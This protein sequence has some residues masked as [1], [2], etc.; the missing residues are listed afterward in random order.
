LKAQKGE[1][2]RFFAFSSS[3]AQ[4]FFLDAFDAL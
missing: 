1:K 3:F 4:S 2:N